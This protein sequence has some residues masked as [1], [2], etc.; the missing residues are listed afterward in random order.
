MKDIRKLI[1]KHGK[2]G[3]KVFIFLGLIFSGIYLKNFYG[4]HTLED[5]TFLMDSFT[6]KGVLIG[7][8]IMLSVI[9]GVCCIPISWSK[10]FGGIYFG[11]VYGLFYGLLAAV[12]SA[13]I[14]FLAARFLGR[15]VVE[16]IYETK[17]RHRLKV[18]QRKYL[19]KQD[20]IGFKEVFILRNIYFVPF[21]LTNYLMGVSKIS[22]RTY[23]SA[24]VLG[25]IPGTATYVYFFANSINFRE[26]PLRHLPVF[27]LVLAYYLSLYL[28]KRRL[29]RKKVLLMEIPNRK[30]VRRKTERKKTLQPAY[31]QG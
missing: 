20:S 12:L 19:E 23:I 17:F 24:S 22:F 10:A 29:E 26:D 30:S 11:F 2:T 13:A 15:E 28:I 1:G 31:Q 9:A 5:L 21:S 27:A 4:I 6:H 7:T 3:L 25:M 16:K 8:F 14:S 18:K